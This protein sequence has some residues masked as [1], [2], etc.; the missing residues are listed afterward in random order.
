MSYNEERLV[1]FE[2]Q[3]EMAKIGFD[4]IVID[5]TNESEEGFFETLEPYFIA[6]A[7]LKGS[8]AYA[9]KDLEKAKGSDK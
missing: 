4:Q 3:F 7:D 5:A 1:N 6:L 2:M 8:V 9:K